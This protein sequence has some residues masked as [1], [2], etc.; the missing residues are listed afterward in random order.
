MDP[1]SQLRAILLPILQN[2]VQEPRREHP[3]VTTNIYD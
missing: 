3:E 2:W 1:V